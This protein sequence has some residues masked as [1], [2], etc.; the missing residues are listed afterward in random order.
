MGDGSK[1][2]I[3]ALFMVTTIE[4]KINDNNKLVVIMFK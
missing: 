1:L 2:T 3:V 4:E